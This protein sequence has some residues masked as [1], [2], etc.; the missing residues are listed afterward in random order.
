[1]KRKNHSGVVSFFAICLL[2][3]PALS[4]T[5]CAEI[6][7]LLLPDVHITAALSIAAN[8]ESASPIKVPHCQVDGVIGKEI[9]FSLI[10]PDTW[11]DRFIMGGG[12]GYVGR[13]ENFALWTAN[14]GYATVG[15]DT[16][17]QARGMQAGWAL[18]NLERQLNFGHLAV[19]RTAEVAKAIVRAR[20]GSNPKFSYF[21]GC[22]R[23]GGAHTWSFPCS[24]PCPGR[25][26]EA[27]NG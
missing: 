17:H 16:G 21:F 11:N 20:Y 5:P 12:G 1:M 13:V 10:L 27:A 23:G 19:H 24:T 22:S 15:T 26:G 14:S 2:A 8:A 6:A 4:Q 9:H 25:D 7:D 3:S 18:D